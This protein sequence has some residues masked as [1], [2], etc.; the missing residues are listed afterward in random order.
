ME[1]NLNEEEREKLRL[2]NEIRKIKLSL[3]MGAKFMEDPG[4]PELPPEIEDEFLNYI[5]QF[6][7]MSADSPKITVFEKI[8]KPHFKL[9][10]EISEEEIENELDKL[11][12]LLNEKGIAIDAIYDVEDR[13]MYRFITEDLFK[14]EMYDMFK[15]EGMV[16]QFTYEE[17]YSNIDEDIKKQA[18][19]FYDSFFNKENNFY[20]HIIAM[21]DK[22]W[23]EDFRNLY[24]H[25]ET[26]HFEIIDHIYD[27]DGA[28]LHFEIDFLAFLDERQSHQFKGKGIMYMY[29]DDY[30]SVNKV[31]FP[32]VT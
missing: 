13:E 8:G 5:E 7:S 30:W 31:Q 25:F 27:D 29:N 9:V 16:T 28:T 22:K 4:M 23:F 14:H 32:H 2:E 15:M 11:H 24:S 20:E 26:K 21:K 18:E 19:D 3:E 1:E 6:E 17:F 12:D 10:A